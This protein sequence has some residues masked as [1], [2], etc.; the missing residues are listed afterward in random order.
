MPAEASRMTPLS[1]EQEVEGLV[2]MRRSVPP[3][4]K[5][6]RPSPLGPRGAGGEG[7][8]VAAMAP[9]ALV[10]EETHVPELA[11][12]GDEGATAAATA[13]KSPETV[14][15]VV[16]LPLSEEYVESE[17]IDP[18]SV[19]STAARIVEFISASEGALGAGTSE[20][21]ANTWLPRRPVCEGT[22]AA[23]KP[24]IPLPSTA[25]N[26][27]RLRP[28]RALIGPAATSSVHSGSLW[29]CSRGSTSRP[30]M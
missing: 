12:A 13:Q 30:R 27:R 8:T 28:G 16:E 19:A 18:A 5:R 15:P 10:V 21:G 14:V 22:W 3:A 23:V 6:E 7:A 1:R 26:G 17:D 20:G 25:M 29:T 24:G 9:T 2:G 4:E 11:K